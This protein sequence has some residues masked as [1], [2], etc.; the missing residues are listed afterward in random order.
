MAFKYRLLD[1]D[2]IINFSKTMVATQYCNTFSFTQLLDMKMKLITTK[3]VKQEVIRNPV[4]KNFMPHI[5]ISQLKKFQNDFLKKISIYDGSD[6]H[7][8]ELTSST[9]LKNL[10]EKSLIC[11]LFE[12]HKQELMNNDIAIVSDN[13]RDVI[14]FSS[15]IKDMIGY[16]K[17]RW[18]QNKNIICLHKFYYELYKIGLFKRHQIGYLMAISNIDARVV[19]GELEAIFKMLLE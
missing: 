15:M 17:V 14:S 13:K 12:R 2:F 3:E 6:L 7:L 1:A 5:N 18:N 10:G 11:L 4:N 9:E 8:M 16:E 19:G